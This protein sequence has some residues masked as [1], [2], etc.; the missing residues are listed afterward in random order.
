[1]T[2]N[3]LTLEAKNEILKNAYNSGTLVT[4]RELNNPHWQET[5]VKIVKLST[6]DVINKEFVFETSKGDR[7]TRFSNNIFFI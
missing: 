7:F 3:L 4:F 5:N 1:M 2:N 6:D